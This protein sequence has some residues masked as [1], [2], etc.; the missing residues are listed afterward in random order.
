MPP[1][2]VEFPLLALVYFFVLFFALGF[3]GSFEVACNV[4]P[5][6]ASVDELLTHVPVAMHRSS[7]FLNRPVDCVLLSADSEVEACGAASYYVVRGVHQVAYTHSIESHLRFLAIWSEAEE[8]HFPEGWSHA[9]AVFWYHVEQV[10]PNL[11]HS[12][13]DPSGNWVFVPA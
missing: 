3:A 1:S 2:V 5:K 13:V 9:A 12:A 7:W 8:D 6:F 10:H 4:M 11:G